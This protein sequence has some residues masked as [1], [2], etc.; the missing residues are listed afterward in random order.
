MNEKTYTIEIK[1][2][3]ITCKGRGITV[4]EAFGIMTKIL[5]ESSIER[6]LNHKT[7]ITKIKAK[8]AK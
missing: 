2:D 5:I 1:N 7:K 8:K 4:Q 3:I 6:A